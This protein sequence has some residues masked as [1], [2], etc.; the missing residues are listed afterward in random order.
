MCGTF[1]S[2]YALTGRPLP[3]HA[4]SMSKVEHGRKVLSLT[5]CTC[6]GWR[7]K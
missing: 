2:A 3:S 6:F 1:Q 5:N 4:G 7:K